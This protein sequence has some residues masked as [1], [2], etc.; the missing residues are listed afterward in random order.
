MRWADI[1]LLPADRQRG[2]VLDATKHYLLNQTG[3]FSTGVLA[4]ELLKID[5]LRAVA[6]VSRILVRLARKGYFKDFAT[7]DGEEYQRYGR[8][9]KRWRWHGRKEKEVWE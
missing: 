7:H 1:A 6:A 4:T 9:N 5:D 2:H 3:T 8:L